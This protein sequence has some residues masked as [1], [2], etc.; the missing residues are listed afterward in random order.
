MTTTWPK[1]LSKIINDYAGIFYFWTQ[2]EMDNAHYEEMYQEFL[3]EE[4]MKKIEDAEN[5]GDD[6][7]D[8][9][10]E[11]VEDEARIASF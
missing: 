10:L 2:E 6:E 8:R 9:W 1:D 7:V 11:E 4:E 5:E 3:Q